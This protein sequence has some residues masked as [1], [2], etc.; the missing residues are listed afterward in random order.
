LRAHAL[1]GTGDDCDFSIKLTHNR[2][3]VIDL[4]CCPAL[5]ECL[6]ICCRTSIIDIVLS[7]K[8]NVKQFLGEK[9]IKNTYSVCP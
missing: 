8:E 3:T 2:T 1:R 4:D 6:P 7:I 9:W 5:A